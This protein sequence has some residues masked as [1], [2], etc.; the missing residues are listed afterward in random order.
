MRYSDL[1]H[2]GTGKEKKESCGFFDRREEGKRE[3]ILLKLSLQ[4]RDA[5]KLKR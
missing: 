3:K 1:D 2:A 4:V 5:G